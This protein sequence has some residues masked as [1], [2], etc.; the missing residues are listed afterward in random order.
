L[1]GIAIGL[2]VGLVA[3]AIV[4]VQASVPGSVAAAERAVVNINAQL[5]TGEAV[6]GTG[7]VIGSNGTVLTNNHVVADAQNISVQINGSGRTYTAT[8]VGVDQSS[9]IAVLS[10]AN[11]SGL[12]TIPLGDSTKVSRGDHVTAVGNAL[13][14]GGA[15]AVTAGQVTALNQTITATDQG[16]GN[17][18]SLNGMIQFDGNIQPGDSGGPLVN[19]SDQVIGMD[20]AGSGR[21]RR[22]SGNVGFAIPINSAV[23]IA[24]Q[25][26]AGKKSG[27]IQIGSR[28][29]IGVEVTDTFDSNGAQVV[30]VEPGSSARRAGIRAGDLITTLNGAS[31]TS[32]SDLS[33]ALS[34]KSPGDRVTVGWQDATGAQ[35]SATVSLGSGPLS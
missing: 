27:G 16:G 32:V 26:T 31:I 25:I 8:V 10:L 15:P 2:I 20:T 23:S 7:M 29:V 14:R 28:G 5:D 13:G 1:V 11:A 19:H 35:H 12:Q 9:D 18:E 6:A 22:I 21:V 3:A 4:I 30:Q 34:G 33:S 17:P 24:N